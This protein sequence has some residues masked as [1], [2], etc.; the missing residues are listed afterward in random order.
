VLELDL[1]L[2]ALGSWLFCL[3]L[4]KSVL[5]VLLNFARALGDVIFCVLFVH[6]TTE[7]ECIVLPFFSCSSSSFVCKN[8][9]GGGSLNHHC[10][11]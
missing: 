3:L 11:F 10:H 2:I 7:C 6:V 9:N 4:H 1:W 5:F 8:L